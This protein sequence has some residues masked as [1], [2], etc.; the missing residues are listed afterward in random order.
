MHESGSYTVAL[1]HEQ[2]HGETQTQRKNHSSAESQAHG[3]LYSYSLKTW[4][5][6]CIKHSGWSQ[7]LYINSLQNS[8]ILQYCPRLF[9]GTAT[10]NFPIFQPHAC[11]KGFYAWFAYFKF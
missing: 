8:L 7:T 9:C 5:T 11:M 4:W 2:Q 6:V 10:S 3:C 1:T